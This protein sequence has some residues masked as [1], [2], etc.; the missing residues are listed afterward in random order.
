MQRIKKGKKRF[1]EQSKEMQQ[2]KRKGEIYRAVRK[3][4]NEIE[5]ERKG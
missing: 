4:C 3:K 2:N 1:M 5:S